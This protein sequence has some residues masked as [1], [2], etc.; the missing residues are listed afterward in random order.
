MVGE[1]NEQTALVLAYAAGRRP[2]PKE[3]TKVAERPWMVGDHQGRGGHGACIASKPLI[4]TEPPLRS[5]GSGEHLLSEGY[6]TLLCWLGSDRHQNGFGPH[7]L[8]PFASDLTAWPVSPQD[9]AKR[10]RLRHLCNGSSGNRFGGREGPEN[11][12][13]PP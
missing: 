12:A 4:P 5:L 11:R 13:H 6:G 2:K 1:R 7:D 3:E 9:W 8:E 10:E